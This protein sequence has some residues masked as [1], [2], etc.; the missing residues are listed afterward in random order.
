LRN[1]GRGFVRVFAH[2]QVRGDAQAD[3]QPLDHLQRESPFAVEHFRNALLAAQVGDQIVCAC[4]KP[5][6][7]S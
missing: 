3:V 5:A 2:Q 7:P 1:A 6:I 4:A